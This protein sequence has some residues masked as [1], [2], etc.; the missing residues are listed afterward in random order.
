MA[1][2]QQTDVTG[3]VGGI[4]KAGGPEP[5]PDHEMKMP[6]DVPVSIGPGESAVGG[7]VVGVVVP[8]AVSVPQRTAVVG[9]PGAPCGTV[10]DVVTLGM[11]CSSL[12]QRR[13]GGEIQRDCRRAGRWTEKVGAAETS[14][15]VYVLPAITE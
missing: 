3:Q 11:Q 13:Q 6:A 1:R 12:F 7:V 9:L 8:N 4:G 10:T 2:G 15:V 5:L 14:P